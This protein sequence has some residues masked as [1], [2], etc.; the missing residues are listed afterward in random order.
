[1]KTLVEVRKQLVVSL[2]NIS[3]KVPDSSH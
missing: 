2:L 1:M 3:E